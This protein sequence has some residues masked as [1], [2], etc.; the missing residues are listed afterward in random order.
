[1]LFRSGFYVNGLGRIFRTA[2]GGRSW[3]RVRDTPGTYFR[4]IGMLDARTGFAGNI[5]TDY[6]P[7]VTDTN[8]LYRTSYDQQAMQ[9]GKP[10]KNEEELRFAANGYTGLQNW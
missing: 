6:F 4:A 2:D 5:G 10:S 7:G 9:S 3:E 1:M 8:P